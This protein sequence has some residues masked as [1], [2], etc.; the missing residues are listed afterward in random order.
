MNGKW[1]KGWEER[2]A[3]L[4]LQK[5]GHS[6]REDGV[7]VMEALAW[8]RDQDHT[9]APVCVSRMIRNFMMTC[10]GEQMTQFRQGDVLVEAAA[11]PEDAKRV[12]VQGRVILAEGEA[13]GHAHTMEADLVE[14]YEREG[15]LYMNV[16]APAPLTHQ[17]HAAI[18]VTPGTYKVTRQREYTPEAIR[19]VQD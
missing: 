9:D 5:G 6:K 16:L 8:L 11:I 7:C 3:Q 10:K 2:L 13:T 15:T 18:T 1:I 14:L 17:E 12:K 4:D 19:N